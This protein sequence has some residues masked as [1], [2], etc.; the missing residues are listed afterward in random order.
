MSAD[1][2]GS[3]LTVSPLPESASPAANSGASAFSSARV[4][5]GEGIYVTSIAAH[6]RNA[7]DL[8]RFLYFSIVNSSFNGKK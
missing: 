7:R 8:L 4:N 5:T 3:A 1:F 6:R 2:L